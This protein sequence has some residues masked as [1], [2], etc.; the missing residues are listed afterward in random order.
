MNR[1]LALMLAGGLILPVSAEAPSESLEDS[2]AEAILKKADLRYDVREYE[3]AL[4][5]YRN[6]IDRFPRSKFRY[7][8]RLRLGRHYFEQKRYEDAVGNLH[9]CAEKS[10][11][12]PEQ[13]E[14]FFLIGVS[15]YN[16]SLYEKAFTKLRE[17][18]ARFPGTDYS[19]KA[20]HYIGMGH[21]RQE[22]YKRAIDAFRMVGT[23]VAQDDPNVKKIAPGKRL[24]VR[25]NDRDLTILSRQNKT[26]TVQIKGRSGDTEQV[27]L[28]T[29]G[30]TGTDFIGSVKTELGEPAAGDGALQVIGSDKIEIAYLDTH[31]N[32]RQR[33]VRRI[34]VV[35]TADDARVDIV[36]GI[37]KAP[38]PAVALNRSASF[39]VIDHDLDSGPTQD[40]IEVIVRCKRE[41]K[42]EA[43]KI[44]RVEELLEQARGEKEKK[45]TVLDEEVV[46]LNETPEEDLADT[47]LS[48]PAEERS[49]GD[50]EKP[51]KGDA[52][53]LAVHSGVFT[54]VLPI[55]EG[56]PKKEDGVIQAEINDVIEV[57]YVDQKRVTGKDETSLKSEA[58]VVKGQI[59]H[60]VPFGGEIQDIDLRIRAKLQVSEAL[61]HM[62]TI[63]KELGLKEQAEAKFQEAL[64]ECGQA[65][66]Q[67]GAQTAKFL[68]K[69]HYLLW[70]IYFA[71]GD[72]QS[73]ARVCLALL[74][75]FPTS[76]FA[77]DALMM[78]GNVAKESSEYTKAISFYRL[79]LSSAKKAAEARVGAGSPEDESGSPLEPD[80]QYAIAEC[81]EGLSATN[82]SY[83]EKAL[84][85]YKRCF[86]AYPTS[87]FAAPSITKIGN[88]YYRTKDYDRAFETFERAIRDYNDAKFLDLL[89]LNSGKCLAVMKKYA[90]AIPRFQR[91]IDDIPASDCVA[92]AIKYRR[93]CEKQLERLRRAQ[94]DNASAGQ[95]H[96]CR[97]WGETQ[98]AFCFRPLR[99]CL[100]GEAV[101]EVRSWQGRTGDPCELASQV[102]EFGRLVR[103][104]LFSIALQT[105]SP[106][107]RGGRG[108]SGLRPRFLT[109]QTGS[110][111][112]R[113]GRGL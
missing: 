11:A 98:I 91:I 52:R 34:H 45:Y 17:V 99:A 67:K 69:M 18:T 27:Q 36:N 12:P 37:F 31:A 104:P 108:L 81:Y 28:F 54:G 5:M 2:R 1:A 49:G 3:D 93:Y 7:S 56:T 8:A 22:H 100:A 6:I 32:D 39:R 106:A 57:E 105:D 44:V 110:P 47:L 77:D 42:D 107:A 53:T 89:L 40:S 90:A 95:C 43:G 21:F 41:I 29:R 50:T 84:V 23:S 15:Y 83:V 94:G 109:C 82:A 73:A 25:V 88:F 87:K 19:N 103:K 78:M 112:A 111:A 51:G 79:L 75:E 92:R 66:R 64:K 55:A 46:R 71:K 20:Y 38:V 62:G 74:R 61:M 85:E 24:F 76:D 68:E 16:Q 86:E 113:G 65:A 33:D 9:E 96:P 10:S 30:L 60:A 4:E 80:A 14:A 97:N 102:N 26:L 48:P 13:A 59:P 35:E 58:V 70:Q 63:Y 101:W 72:H